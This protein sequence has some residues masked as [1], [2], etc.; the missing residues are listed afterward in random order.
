MTFREKVELM[1]GDCGCEC[2]W[3]PKVHHQV[4]CCEADKRE[5]PYFNKR[6]N[7][8]ISEE[9]SKKRMM[10]RLQATGGAFAKEELNTLLATANVDS[11][12]DGPALPH[13]SLPE[14]RDRIIAL[15]IRM[16]NLELLHA[17]EGSKG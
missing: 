5:Y 9:E 13:I 6:G 2:H 17:H 12:V 3:N 1:V 16:Q 4:P 8:V 11:R 7:L 10:L 14:L 15:E